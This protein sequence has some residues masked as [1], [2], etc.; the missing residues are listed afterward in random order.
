MRVAK[1]ETKNCGAKY[2]KL[3]KATDGK[4]SISSAW[5]N[6]QMIEAFDRGIHSIM[7]SGMFELFTGVYSR[8]KAGNREGAKKLF[9]D[10]LPIITFTRQ[11]QSL[12]RKFHKRYLKA[13]GIFKTDVSREPVV[14]DEYDE[15]Y[16]DELIE[17]ARNIIAH[18]DEY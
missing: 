17:R 2:T 10:I 4:L 6:D 18:L 9:Y 12:N 13:F 8:Y 15:R 14:F 3:L 1:I 16:A 5:G 7:P 11:E